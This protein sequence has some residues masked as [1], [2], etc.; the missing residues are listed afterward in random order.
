MIML[1]Y[2]TQYS[3]LKKRLG[4]DM[5]R[6]GQYIHLHPQHNLRWMKM[7][8]AFVEFSNPKVFQHETGRLV[9]LLA[10]H[11]AGLDRH[12]LLCKFYPQYPTASWQLQDSL[13]QTLE[14]AIQRARIIFASFCMNIA[15]CKIDKLYRLSSTYCTNVTSEQ[16]HIQETTMVS[17]EHNGCRRKRG[18][19]QMPQDSGVQESD[20]A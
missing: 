7:H 8:M 17:V 20:A 14:K 12:T 11:P 13:R 15:Y 5:G 10:Q 1:S 2:E 16:T 4:E 6:L 19:R 9:L 3:R 18:S